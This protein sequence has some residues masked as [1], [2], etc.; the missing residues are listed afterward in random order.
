MAAQNNS[1]NPAHER[2]QRRIARRRQHIL[3]AAA[4]MFASKGYAGATT[5]EIAKEADMGESTLYN[6]FKSKREIL[7][8]IASETETPFLHAVLNMEGETPREQII[9]MFE[10]A[11][12]ISDLQLPYTRTVL[13]EVWLD[14]ETLNRFFVPRL[15]EV[16]EKLKTFIQQNVD[17]GRFRPVDP[18]LGAQLAIG[19][20][21]TFWLPAVRGAA[22]LPTPEKRRALAESLADVLL[23]GVRPRPQANSALD[24]APAAG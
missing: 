2:R 20:F 13:T 14:D 19:M 9:Y 10:Q 8:A 11:L 22:P 5:K 17:A 3:K 23:D 7:L 15:V 16:Y 21:A 24:N 18:Q 4:A 1:E 12:K 6:Y